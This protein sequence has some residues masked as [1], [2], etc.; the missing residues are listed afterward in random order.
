M[1]LIYS[2]LIVHHLLMILNSTKKNQIGTMVLSLQCTKVW[3][4]TKTGPCLPTWPVALEDVTIHFPLCPT[5]LPSLQC[6]A[7]L[8][9]AMQRSEERACHQMLS[10]PPIVS[11]EQGCLGWIFSHHGNSFFLSAQKMKINMFGKM[12]TLIIRRVTKN[13]TSGMTRVLFGT[14]S[15]SHYNIN[16]IIFGILTIQTSGADTSQAAFFKWFRCSLKVIETK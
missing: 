8:H 12:G 14:T 6:N 3:W 16:S 13:S 4:D 7:I 5:W 1:T 9:C 11:Q 15:V 2:A 10:W